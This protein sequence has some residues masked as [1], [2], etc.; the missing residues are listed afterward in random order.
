MIRCPIAQDSLQTCLCEGEGFV[1]MEQ[2][3][4]PH[5]ALY[6]PLHRENILSYNP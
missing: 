1:E 3:D 6:S 4:F 2:Q 5:Q